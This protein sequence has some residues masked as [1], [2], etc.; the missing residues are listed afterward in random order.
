ME[1]LVIIQ[2]CFKKSYKK[3]FAIIAKPFL[4]FNK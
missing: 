3:G 1:L 2:T 4:V